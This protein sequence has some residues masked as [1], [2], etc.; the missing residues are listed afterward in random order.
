MIDSRTSRA[1]VRLV[2]YPQHVDA[3]PLNSADV[4]EQDSHESSNLEAQQ[5]TVHLVK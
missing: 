2:N 4:E 3:D 1:S 5:Q